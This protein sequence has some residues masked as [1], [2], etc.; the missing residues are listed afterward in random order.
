M[1][2][3]IVAITVLLQTSRG[4]GTYFVNAFD[5]SIHESFRAKCSSG[6]PMKFSEQRG[7]LIP[8]AILYIYMSAAVVEGTVLDRERCP[9][10]RVF[11]IAMGVPL[12]LVY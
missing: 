7:V 4:Q 9:E 3:E 12:Q 5:I 2:A 10:F 8:R 6:H 11:D 1:I